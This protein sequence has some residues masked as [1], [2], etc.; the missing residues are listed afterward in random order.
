M[1]APGKIV[2]EIENHELPPS[3][4]PYKK[5]SQYAVKVIQGIIKIESDIRQ[6][7]PGIYFTSVNVHNPGPKEAS[8]YVKLAISGRNG[9]PG[10]I[11]FWKKFDLK[12]DEATEFDATGFELLLTLTGIPFPDFLEGY[13]VIECPLELDVVGVYTGAAVQNEQL[14]AIHLERVSKRLIIQ[15]NYE[16][17]VK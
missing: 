2:P 4:R 17:S 6:I 5:V 3:P 15:G 1:L 7:G 16:H 8:F 12:Y 14:G 9:T 10:K 13:F 11:S